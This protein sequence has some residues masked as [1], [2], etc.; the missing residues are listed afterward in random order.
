MKLICFRIAESITPFLPMFQS[1][2]H[3]TSSVMLKITVHYTRALTEKASVFGMYDAVPCAPMAITHPNL[4]L[5]PGRPSVRNILNGAID[6]VLQY[7]AGVGLK[8]SIDLSGLVVGICG[9]QGLGDGVMSAVGEVDNAARASI[10]GIE[11][12]EE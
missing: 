5:S 9:P 12:H 7:K 8:D 10:G 1:L 11:V 2:V 6:S 4:T 3:Q